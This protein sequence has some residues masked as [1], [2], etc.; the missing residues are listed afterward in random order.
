MLQS[1]QPPSNVAPGN[2]SYNYQLQTL[3]IQITITHVKNILVL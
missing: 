2:S 1:I 3:Y